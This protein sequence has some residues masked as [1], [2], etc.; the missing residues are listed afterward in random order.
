MSDSDMKKCYPK[1]VPSRL[2]Q[3]LR[4]V[5][6][7]DTGA[8]HSMRYISKLAESKSIWLHLEELKFKAKRYFITYV[9][10]IIKK[11]F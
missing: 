9:A 1:L 7:R 3:N 10:F 2:H 5:S 11:I 4:Y 6:L 8:N